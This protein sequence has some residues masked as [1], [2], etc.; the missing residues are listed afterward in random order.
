[1]P[2]IDLVDVVGLGHDFCGL[3]S[4]GVELVVLRSLRYHFFL[5]PYR[6]VDVLALFT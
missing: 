3:I 1:M 2:G 6:K 4:T 5:L